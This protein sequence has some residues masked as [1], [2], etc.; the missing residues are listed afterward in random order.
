MAYVIYDNNDNI[1]SLS[2]VTN[3]MTAESVT[4]ATVS[5][6][7]L[8]AGAVVSGA[9][10]VSMVATSGAKSTYRGT[11]PYSLTLATGTTYTAEI[12]VVS[13]ALH[14]QWE[15]PVRCTTRTG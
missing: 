12:T 5:L 2:S 10:G 8:N 6:R 15:V 9:S 14:G 7:L 3:G 11:L 13:G 4:G 1:V